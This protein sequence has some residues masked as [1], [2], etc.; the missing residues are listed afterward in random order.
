[1]LIFTRD[2]SWNLRKDR[3]RLPPW[4]H[5]SRPLSAWAI[6]VGEGTFHGY[7]VIGNKKNKK[8]P[9]FLA[10]LFVI[11]YWLQLRKNIN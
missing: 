3:L 10:E 1:M 7:I 6:N 8:E 5:E 11:K 2:V 4:F 9:K